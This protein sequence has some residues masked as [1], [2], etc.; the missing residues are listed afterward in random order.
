[1]KNNIQLSMYGVIYSFAIHPLSS[2]E[3]WDIDGLAQDWYNSIA[4]ALEITVI[5][6]LHW[7]IDVQSTILHAHRSIGCCMS[8]PIPFVINVYEP[9]LSCPV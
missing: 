3:I 5:T 7:A 9:L 8:H 6:V 4:N 2:Y 1:M